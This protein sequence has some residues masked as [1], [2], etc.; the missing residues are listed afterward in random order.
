MNI[1]NL[2]KLTKNSPSGTLN[3]NNEKVRFIIDHVDKTIYDISVE[4]GLMTIKNK[5]FC[6]NK[7][8]LTISSHIDTV[9]ENSFVKIDDTKIC[10][11]LDNSATNF[12]LLELLNTNIN[13]QIVY[14]FTDN[15]ELK[16]SSIQTS[17]LLRNKKFLYNI[18]LDVTIFCHYTHFATIENDYNKI[19]RK[20]KNIGVAQIPLYQC[21]ND[22]TN[23][24]ND[25]GIRGFSF[26]LPIE[27]HENRCHSEEGG[28]ISL[29][30]FETYY[31]FLCEYLKNIFK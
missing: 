4:K 6:E 12:I 31:N 30:K 20:I 3:E 13:P 1:N 25:M 11:T 14:F 9:Y 10:G 23:T 16:N 27:F 18:C 29:N 5:Q 17:P 22:E 19:G 8:F 26:C 2:Y 24:I 21:A 7:R 15:E 28:T